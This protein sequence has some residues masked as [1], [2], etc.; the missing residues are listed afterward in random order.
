MHVFSESRVLTAWKT[1]SS[2]NCTMTLLG[3]KRKKPGEPPPT[4]WCR[5][6]QQLS[7]HEQPV[8]VPGGVVW[9]CIMT[10]LDPA[11]MVAGGTHLPCPPPLFS[12]R[13]HWFWP[14][15]GPVRPV[16]AAWTCEAVISVWSCEAREALGLWWGPKF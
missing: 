8:V 5:G 4:A 2:I 6:V 9:Q 14:L 7:V 11:P 10:L 12:L 13:F 16:R 3:P 15:S 1:G